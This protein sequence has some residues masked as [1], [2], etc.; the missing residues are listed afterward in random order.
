MP[1]APEAGRD[2]Q[3]RPRG[4]NAL[5]GGDPRPSQGPEGQTFRESGDS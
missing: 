3:R 1:F 5:T 2:K 4:R